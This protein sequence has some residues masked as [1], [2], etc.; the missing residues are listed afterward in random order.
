MSQTIGNVHAFVSV[1]CTIRFRSIYILSRSYFSFSRNRLTE[2]TSRLQGISRQLSDASQL[3]R[4]IQTPL[5][6]AGEGSRAGLSTDITALS[7]C[8]VCL[9]GHG[10]IWYGEGRRFCL[11]RSL[12]RSW[13]LRTMQYMSIFISGR[14]GT[15]VTYGSQPIDRG[16]RHWEAIRGDVR[17]ECSRGRTLAS[18][19]VAEEWRWP[20][21]TQSHLLLSP[22]RKTG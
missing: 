2:K 5:S 13:G 10:G 18:E 8:G 7:Q 16:E 17:L 11:S 15:A 12:R 9:E 1:S 21:G 3:P 6:S 4:T 22:A 14:L 19:R 20:S